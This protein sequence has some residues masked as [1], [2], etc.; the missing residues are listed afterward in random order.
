[1]P[2]VDTTAL[3]TAMDALPLHGREAL[4]ARTVR[5]A[6]PAE[7]DALIGELT[8]RGRYGRR[9]AAFAAVL[10][11]RADLLGVLLTD[12]D[13]VVRGRA[14]DALRTVPELAS[15]VPDA[16]RR[17]PHAVRQELRAAVAR[18]RCAELAARLLPVARAHGGEAE[19][20]T[21]LP[22]CPPEVVAAELPGLAVPWDAWW[23]L[24]SRHPDAVL[25]HV[26]R[27]L[28]ARPAGAAADR[29]GTLNLSLA[30]VLP[31]R[32]ARV[33]DL[34]EHHPGRS[35]P[36][37]A[38]EGFGHLLAVDAERATAWLAAPERPLS[39]REQP[40][41]RTALDRLVRADPP[42]LTAL[43][44]RWLPEPRLFAP[45]LRAVP[46]ARRAAFL[47][48]AA[49]GQPLDATRLTEP[50]LRLLP[51]ERRW[52]EA[53]RL[54]AEQA[55]KGVS[56][57]QL[58]WLTALVEPEE[59][60]AELLGRTRL[61]QAADRAEAWR[62]LV[63]A[64]AADRRPA[65]PAVLLADLGRLRNE[66]DPVREAALSALAAFPAHRFTDAHAEPLT[67]LAATAL[68]ARDCSPGSRGALAALA[69]AVLAAGAGPAL[70]AF[71]CSTLG[72][73]ADRAGEFPLPA[74]VGRLRPDRQRQVLEALRPRLDA[75]RR[76][77]GAALLF[78]L[79]RALDG[80]AGRL[81]ELDERLAEA[82][83]DP[84]ER[85][86]AEALELWLRPRAGRTGKVLAA[87]A[88]DP[89][90]VFCAPVLRHA[91]LA[92][93]DLLDRALAER[94]PAGRFLRPGDP[95][96]LPPAHDPTR[97][98]PR[99]V[100]RAAA[101]CARAAADPALPE[102]QRAAAVARAAL[103]LEPGAAVVRR[104]LDAPQPLL[105][106]TAL[107][108]LVRTS[109]PAAVLPELLAHAGGD[110]AKVAV[111]AAGRAARRTA[112]DQLAELLGELAVRTEGTKVTARKEAVRLA[113]ALLPPARAAGVLTAAFHAPGQ[114]PDVRAAA[115]AHCRGLLDAEPLWTLLAEAA[116]APGAPLRRAVA[117]Q[118]PHLLPERHRARYARLVA[119]VAA[120]ADA[121][122][123]ATR[124][125]LKALPEW[126]RYAPEV[127]EVLPAA[128]TDLD[129][130]TT[131]RT[132]SLAL[133]ALAVSEL[134]HPTGGAAPGSLLHRALAA[135][136]AAG[137]GS[138][139]PSV[140]RDQPVRQRIEALTAVPA[141]LRHREVRLA[142]AEHLR[143]HEELLDLRATLLAR[144]ADP[145]G[146]GFGAD[147]ARLAGALA[148][149]PVSAA[150]LATR[151]AGAVAGTS[152]LPT[153]A[154]TAAPGALLDLL[155]GRGPALGLFATALAEQL[156]TRCA[157]TG[158]W[159]PLLAA[160]RAHPDAEVRSAAR[161]VV[162][163]PE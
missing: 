94:P 5:A 132:A 81:P 83:R 124:T 34:L 156:G 139:P 116:A 25:D 114:H 121:D 105:A 104:H 27:E 137:P 143:P 131:W 97:W 67:A 55:A 120:G 1:M 10:A 2:H 102:E 66:Q 162:V 8:D 13:R 24:G 117:G 43:G 134:P 96:P 144:A 71:A 41:S 127:A 80:R 155:P 133:R 14:V 33:L 12:P 84:R 82:A 148:D 7:V 30:P 29:W 21:L 122:P 89:S 40:P 130:R 152:T 154:D 86:A 161:A 58:L 92:R 18:G 61:P 20:A 68:D 19:A 153:A 135:L 87:L 52:Q 37:W 50:V 85:T 15:A 49:D 110:R 73:L 113:A 45:L 65:A 99:Q 129:N 95:R 76:T 3:L 9:L 123:E 111:Y 53:R 44:R 39:R 78:A 108:A 115:T 31:L 11:A 48:A 42:S 118:P 4:F 126:A 28:A 136:L 109:D 51:R 62:R 75:E 47:D 56:G 57:H 79:V 103:L 17:A 128:A 119:A 38:L 54:R 70:T 35:A 149:H 46:P 140:A 23:A 77:G 107:A 88:H 147:V 90:A 93:T 142:L 145:A 112:P 64:A 59:A 98:T 159:L 158:R 6:A 32:P 74:R 106:D 100:E 16:Y 138:A 151:L 101:L 72:R 146:P 157:W 150:R 22:A 125:A 26:G 163:A 69:V 63:Q 91:A 60:R 160:L 36:S 141:V